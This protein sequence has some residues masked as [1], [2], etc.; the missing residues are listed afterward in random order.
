MSNKL[1]LE[2]YEKTDW[3]D[4]VYENHRRFNLNKEDGSLF[5]TFN[6][7]PNFGTEIQRGTPKNQKHM[8]N[9]EEGIYV[10]REALISLIDR[11][12]YLELND[13]IQDGM[14][15]MPNDHTFKAYMSDKDLF[16]ITRGI[17]DEDTKSLMLNEYKEESDK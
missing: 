12:I 9:I 8:N 3:K 6:L 7:N 4:G 10:N 15:G 2:R 1:N 16:N 11:V 13:S 14:I 17:Y 5:G